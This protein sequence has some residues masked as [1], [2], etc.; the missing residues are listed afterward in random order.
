MKECTENAKL[1]VSDIDGTYTTDIEQNN[2]A[3]ENFRTKGNVFA[4]CTGRCYNDFLGGCRLWDLKCDYV[5]TDNGATVRQGDK[6]ISNSV[7]PQSIVSEIIDFTKEN[8]E[9]V[10]LHSCHG[11][12]EDISY[13]PGETIKITISLRDEISAVRLEDKIKSDFADK[14]NCC[15][16][17][18]IAFLE[19]MAHGVSKASA[20]RII[21]EHAGIRQENIFTVGDAESDISM[22]KA[23]NGYAIGTSE[24]CL[25][26][27]KKISSVHELIEKEVLL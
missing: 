10:E 25:A 24:K 21:A 13:A 12:S 22:L 27:F 8:A 15:K 20:S 16:V 17:R 1:I 14:V 6:I 9:K 19:I 3:V 7:I 11:H 23:F 5:A 18:G 26:D 4:F 2:V